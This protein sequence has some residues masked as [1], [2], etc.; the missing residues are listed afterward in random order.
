[1]LF[2]GRTELFMIE[3]VKKL[4]G[5]ERLEVI[6]IY[7]LVLDKMDCWRMYL[8]YIFL[9]SVVANLAHRYCAGKY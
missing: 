2:D 5:V 8:L 4:N 6:M 3:V 9:K 1:M 7:N